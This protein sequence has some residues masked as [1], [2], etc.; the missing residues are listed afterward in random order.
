MNSGGVW[1]VEGMVNERIVASGIYYYTSDNI[2]ESRLSFR[3]AVQ[4]P[5]YEQSDAEG[6]EVV[7]GLRDE[8]PLNQILGSIITKEGRCI[9]FPNTVQHQVNPFEVKS[10]TKYRCEILNYCH[11][12]MYGLSF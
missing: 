10:A 12:I 3:Q 7:Y 11:I 5:G 2:S 9:A 1:H 8:E 6:V 4:E